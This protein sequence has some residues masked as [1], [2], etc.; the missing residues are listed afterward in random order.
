MP[1]V[2]DDGATERK[3]YG[4]LEDIAIKFGDAVEKT[5]LEWWAH[6][7]RKLSREKHQ[8]FRPQ[9]SDAGDVLYQKIVDRHSKICF[10]VSMPLA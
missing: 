9:V 4:R 6:S 3:G 7:E 2:A 10:Q 8:N 1:L 5:V